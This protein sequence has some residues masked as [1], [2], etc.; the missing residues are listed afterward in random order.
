MQ[1]E[2]LKSE[3]ARLKRA[4]QELSILNEIATAIS[5]MHSLDKIVALI[6]DKCVKHLRVEQAAVMLVSKEKEG[7]PFQTM[8][9]QADSTSEIIPYRLNTQLTGWMLKYQKPLVIDDFESDD[10]LTHV[11]N[12]LFPIRSLLSVP[13]TLKGRMI[14]LI[15]VFNK[16]TGENYNAD[17]QRLLSIIASQ[18]AQI[19]ENAR[20]SEEEQELVRM[21][22][23]MRMAMEI[24]TKLLPKTSPVLAGYDIAGLSIPARVVGGDYFDFITIDKNRLA[25]CLGDV[26]GKGLPAALLMANL[27]ATIRSQVIMDPTPG[28]CLHRSNLLLYNSTDSQKFATLIYG[29]LDKYD[30]QFTFSNAGHNRPIY[31]PEK[32][33][34][35]IVETAG[36]ALSFEQ[37]TSYAESKVTF[38]T[39]DIFLIYSDGVNEAANRDA[40][41][42][43]EHRI[44]EIAQENM[45]RSAS[46][47]INKI[48][49]AVDDHTAG[50]QQRDDMTLVVIKR[51]NRKSE[52][53]G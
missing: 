35:H 41:E 11:D 28:A 3:N 44:L 52:S 27:Q 4:V 34:P 37:E 16:R 42:F 29:V 13:M 7:D 24:Q 47:I 49:A 19:I 33:S 1:T 26:S 48:I 2:H 5:S 14:G 20:L 18:S 36:I 45:H 23:E 31:F 8:I 22:H 46:E 51:L 12:E 43:G 6:V 17:D 50:F 40:D 21:Q 10:R 25:I 9:R 38:N 32:D 53:D 39:G 15:T 30:D